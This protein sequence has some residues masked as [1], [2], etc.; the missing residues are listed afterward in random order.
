MFIDNL[1]EVTYT[2][3]N[4][5]AF[6]GGVEMLKKIRW[7][8][9]AAA[10]LIALFGVLMFIKPDLTVLTLTKYVG[11]VLT[12]V[13]IVF[14]LAYF[15]RRSAPPV[16]YDLA[17][18]LIVTLIGAYIYLEADVV[19]DSL[20]QLLGAFII[21]SGI[22]KVQKAANMHRMGFTSWINVFIFSM[23][24]TLIGFIV[25]LNPFSSV[26][27][28]MRATAAGLVFSGAVGVVFVIFM[29]AKVRDFEVNGKG[30]KAAGA[31]SSQEDF[32]YDEDLSREA[33]EKEK[34]RWKKDRTD[35]A[36]PMENVTAA[37]EMDIQ[38][39]DGAAQESAASEAAEDA[40][41]P[42]NAAAQDGGA[43]PENKAEA[44]AAET[45]ADSRE[46]DSADE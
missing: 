20:P 16:G 23:I 2:F 46:Q 25:V 29:A 42:Q 30:G 22:M 27:W 41:A 17:I 4:N 18:G 7:Q 13:G 31:A 35:N 3:I 37:Q 1:Q 12:A 10:V 44:S 40:A 21:I 5:A 39:D 26:E 43:S 32:D 15:V 14:I 34:R 45:Q 33:P 38:P 19:D 6:N 9:L 36:G 11:L 28:Q 24:N 8:E